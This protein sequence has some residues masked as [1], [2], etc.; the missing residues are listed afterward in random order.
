M[1]T[2][3][4][5]AEPADLP[6]VLDLLARSRLPGDGLADHVGTLLVARAGG[7]LVGSAALELYGSSALLRSVA[8][9]E[10]RRGTGLGQRLTRAALD[11]ARARGV[12]TIYLLT[13]TAGEFFPRFGFQVVQRD[14]VDPNVRQSAEFTTLCPASAVAMAA[15]LRTPRS[16]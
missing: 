15:D 6:A 12:R 11:L 10:H 7:Q 14:T 8:V 13:E 5:A 16:A 3:I 2:T 4:T 1:A 9:D